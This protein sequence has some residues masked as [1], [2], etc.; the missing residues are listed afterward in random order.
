MKIFSQE[1]IEAREFLNECGWHGPANMKEAGLRVL[2]VLIISLAIFLIINFFTNGWLWN[3][4][5]R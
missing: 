1:E 4:I 2:S 3:Y 5:N